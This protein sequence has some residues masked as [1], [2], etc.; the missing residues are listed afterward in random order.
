MLSIDNWSLIAVAFADFFQPI[1]PPVYGAAALPL[2][3]RGIRSKVGASLPYVDHK[4]LDSQL[5]TVPADMRR[6]RASR[7]DC[8]PDNAPTSRIKVRLLS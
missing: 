7:S 2:E 5:I 1:S 4:E 3:L 6:L 8:C